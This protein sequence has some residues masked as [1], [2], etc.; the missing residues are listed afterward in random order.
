MS[1]GHDAVVLFINKYQ[2]QPSF[3]RASVWP[4]GHAPTNFEKWK[5]T[6][7]NYKVMFIITKYFIRVLGSCAVSN[8]RPKEKSIPL[9][10][11][12]LRNTCSNLRVMWH[13]FGFLPSYKIKSVYTE[14]QF[15]K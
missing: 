1:F 14:K 9:F 5:N 11:I 8:F 13:L 7:E 6:Q 10:L 3:C 4:Q 12:V 2:P 15:G